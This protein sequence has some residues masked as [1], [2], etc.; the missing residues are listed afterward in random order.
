M[1]IIRLMALF[2]HVL[3]I[4]A[5][6]SPR[7]NGLS[8]RQAVTC[9]YSITASDGDTCT[10]VAATWGLTDAGFEA[11]NP[12]ADCPTLTVGQSYCVLGSVST[13]TTTTATT[14]ITTATTATSITTK[15]TTTSQP[16][17]TSKATTTT[18]P[19]STTKATTT[20]T[21]SSPH[22]PSQSGLASN[23][24][25]FYQ[26]QSGDTCSI[27]TFKYEISLS[28]F[29]TWNPSIDSACD[30]L[31]VGYWVCVGV[32]GAILEPRD[33]LDLRQVLPGPAR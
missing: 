29:D 21:T 12:G 16:S 19:T 1:A 17:I 7:R 23:C 2:V 8:L 25:S 18:V 14:T 9:Y 5:V 4:L 15:A 30:N 31:Y 28:E 20:T 13:S 32:P 11:L 26:V 6:P 33:H 24:N 22:S 10:S 3:S 27:I